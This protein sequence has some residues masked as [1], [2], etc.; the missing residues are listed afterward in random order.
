MDSENG[1]VNAFYVKGPTI[2]KYTIPFTKKKVDDILY[3]KHSFGE[4]SINITDPE[5]VVY[6]G[7]RGIQT[8]RCADYTYDQFVTPEWKQFVELASV[9]KVGPAVERTK[10]NSHYVDFQ[11][12]LLFSLYFC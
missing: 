5:S 4:D 12:L 6:Y 10:T 11:P 3:S 2:E 9:V 1:R 7:G 8:M